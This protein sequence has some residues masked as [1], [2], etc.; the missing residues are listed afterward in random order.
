M[1]DESE[2]V[3]AMFD[4]M[5]GVVRVLELLQHSS[6]AMEVARAVSLRAPGL[7][8]LIRQIQI[9]VEEMKRAVN[10]CLKEIESLPDQLIA[11]DDKIADIA[12]LQDALRD[13]L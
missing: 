7:N 11:P 3:R 2:R 8:H 9:K 13:K 10:A 12:V 6:S 1:A 4:L 5:P